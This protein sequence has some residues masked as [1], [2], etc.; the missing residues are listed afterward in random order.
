MVFFLAKDVNLNYKQANFLV[1]STKFSLVHN[2]FSFFYASCYANITIG[3][4]E[5]IE[6]W[7]D[8]AFFK[9]IIFYGRYIDDILLIWSGVSNTLESF[10]KHCNN[11]TL[12]Q[13]F[14]YVVDSVKLVFLN[15]ELSHEEDVIITRNHWK[16]YEW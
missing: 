9:F 4:W 8:Y 13:N 10:L 16:T 6:I 12:G 5:E 14:T 7:N 11:N 3:Y 1:D 15:L 2:N